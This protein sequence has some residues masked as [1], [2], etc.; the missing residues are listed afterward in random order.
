[1]PSIMNAQKKA[2]QRNT[3]MELIV[4]FILDVFAKKLFDEG[5][6]LEEVHP[7]SQKKFYRDDCQDVYDH[8]LRL[9]LPDN[10]YLELWGQT[11]CYKG[12]E[13][14]TESNKTYEIRET[15]VECLTLRKWLTKEKVAHRTLHFTIGDP[16]YTYSWFQA[17]KRNTFDFSIY[18]IF[19]GTDGD[20][21]K[22]VFEQLGNI[23]I[24]YQVR[25]ALEKILLNSNNPIAEYIS[26]FVDSLYTWFN[27]G[28]P[29]NKTALKQVEL[30]IRKDVDT[31]EIVKTYI[32][33][34]RGSGENIKGRAQ[35]LLAGGDVA[36][37][38]MIQTLRRL[39]LSN[40]FLLAA[41]EALVSWEKWAP[42]VFSQQ[43]DQ[44][45]F[46]YFS[47]LWEM[48]VPDRYVVRRLLLRMYSPDGIDYIQDIKVPGVDEHNLY[49]G[50]HSK[51]QISSIAQIL[52]NR[53]AQRS[54]GSV[55]SVF[56]VLCSPL[57][58]SMLNHARAF[59][60]KNGT[61]LKPSFFYLEEFLKPD[62]K[63]VSFCETDLPDPI[64]FQES[65]CEDKTGTY[66]NLKVIVNASNRPLAII[67]GK[68][69]RRQEFPRRVKEESYV[70]LTVS[71]SFS[72]E[73]FVPKYD[74][75]LIMFIDMIEDYTPPEYTIRRLINYGWNPYFNLNHLKQDLKRM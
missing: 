9:L 52:A 53:Y 45:L 39:T 1:M 11:T 50:E 64:G 44:N 56:R 18:P 66:K 38:I 10:S 13:G 20:I 74:I 46:Q 21:F 8:Y 65:F 60:S 59:E 24:E 2:T 47:R 26:D 31:A 27:Q 33:S 4:D 15:L 34:S 72:D 7:E 32:E 48:P 70:G 54:L 62:F 14:K 49:S 57:A 25:E 19:K 35:K 41:A 3:L 51:Y 6:I 29:A 73:R 58:K 63:L 22:N 68:F 37:P 55:E 23:T 75:P 40:P 42:C 69:F 30:L 17:A 67:K 71:Y 61:D 16:S 5:K 36:D 43:G 28:Y 12:N